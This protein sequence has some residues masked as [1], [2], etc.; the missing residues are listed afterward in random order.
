MSVRI[1]LTV[2]ML[3]GVMLQSGIQA[4]RGG[5]AA[6]PPIALTALDYFEI[7]QLVAKYARASSLTTRTAVT[8]PLTSSFSASRPSTFFPIRLDAAPMLF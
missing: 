4:Q 3:V 2:A 5:P 1:L 6:T 7:Q 8:N